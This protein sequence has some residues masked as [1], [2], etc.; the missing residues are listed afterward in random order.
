MA[1]MTENRPELSLGWV[2]FRL[3]ELRQ[4][5]KK[6]VKPEDLGDTGY[7]TV[8]KGALVDLM[9]GLVQMKKLPQ[10]QDVLLR[11]RGDNAPVP[12]SVKDLRT[13]NVSLKAQ[14]DALAATV[15]ELSAKR[16]PGR[17]PK[18]D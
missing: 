1:V 17:P 3:S 7:E 12:Q 16:G 9:N 2:A 8:S 18:D 6:Y 15:A 14:L 13:E 10:Y 5:C 4:I 11:E